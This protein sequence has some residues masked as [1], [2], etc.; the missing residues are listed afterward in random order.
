M[1]R[2]SFSLP[3][4][5]HDESLRTGEAKEIAEAATANIQ[6]EITHMIQIVKG[7]IL[8]GALL[9]LA[10]PY[11]SLSQVASSSHGIPSAVPVVTGDARVDKLLAEMTL[12]E[13][14]SLVH[15]ELEP[16]KKFQG[17]PGFLAGIPRLGI[18]PLRFADG[19]PGVLTRIPSGGPVSTMGLAATFSRE[20][21]KA[22]GAMVARQA[23]A[24]GMDVVL[25][26]FINID[27]DITFSRSY[28]TF[29]ED[30]L[31]TGEIGAS[32]IRGVQ[33]NGVMSMAKHYVAYDTE[34][35][36]VTVGE[37]ALHEIYAAP[38]AAAS[39]AG[40]AAIMCSYNKLNG[41]YSCGNGTSLNRILKHEIGFQGFVT[42]D[43]GAVHQNTAING[44]VDMEMP[45]AGS[46]LP[47]FFEYAPPV[48][49]KR[50]QPSKDDFMEE[51][52]GVMPEEGF[53]FH[54]VEGGPPQNMWSALHAHEVN[55]STIT[56]AAG[57]LL[58][59]MDKF[60][61]LDNGTHHVLSADTID[62]NAKVIQKTGEDAAV[63]LK[64]D[65]RALPLNDSDLQS[66]ALIGP[67]ALQTIAVAHPIEKAV[68]LPERQIGTL[69]VLRKYLGD[70][71]GRRVQ[72]AVADDLTGNPVPAQVL[73]HD[74][75]PGIVRR[76][77]NKAASVVAVDAQIDFT[78]KKGN[79]LPAN[80]S[81]DWDGT[82]S[83]PARAKYHMNLQ[84]LGCYGVL[85]IDG[86]RIISNGP[87]SL[88]GEITQAGQDGVLPT[89]DGLDNLRALVELA[90]G[91]HQISVSVRPDTSSN[92]AQVRLNWVT[93]EEQ[94][95]NYADSV[96]LAGKV[97]TAVV[98]AWSRSRGGG[99]E[100]PGNQNK[101]I[102][103]IA[104]IN[105]NTIV[106][107]NVSQPVLMPWIG[108]VKAVLQM[109]WPGDE[110]GWSTANV[111]TGRVNPGG[112]LPFTWGHSL[113]EYPMGD[114]SHP[115]RKA[116]GVDG[117]TIFSE[118]I[119]IGYRWFDKQNIDPL[120]PFGFGLSY[121]KFSYSKV[122][123]VHTDDGG[124]DVSFTLQNTGARDGDEVAQVYVDGPV[125]EPNDGA[126]FAIRS[127]AG[128]ERV[129]LAAGEAKVVT[130]HIAPRA[131]EYWS[132]AAG[133]WETA[134]GP[135]KVRVGASS[136]DL[137]LEAELNVQ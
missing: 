113:Q 121:T 110:G 116:D 137:R 3:V 10:T 26:P 53:S 2:S 13:K 20:D 128:F 32:F 12:A 76:M 6:E 91:P 30:P 29:G 75:K 86:R 105:P 100:L 56:A 89:T 62:M 11:V 58:L 72:F 132:T 87:M 118:G 131:F 61:Y 51:W 33:A 79:A 83:V 31:L 14:I 95:A 103:D 4:P 96:A 34:G 70:T 111:L 74:G 27:R 107:L 52:V 85:R 127:L 1:R 120:F 19:P 60:G 80:S 130:L 50:T 112:R 126:Q 35:D 90:K 7:P 46:W 54:R 36:D 64:N 101:L 125:R 42:S 129:H 102:E 57:R 23:A 41:E 98:F 22:N 92:P 18:P 47:N 43:W 65:S 135:R 78:R 122:K 67:G 17:Q 63:L 109:W 44:G 119:L 106:V 114:P 81:F 40:V 69:D 134:R 25:E 104:A 55:E 39:A 16:S 71:D 94:E 99:M 48:P 15:G 77:G 5:F 123:L 38:F 124:E 88:H 93:P 66:V 115:E 24:R 136:R 108:K 49:P 9:L 82:I 21:A 59:Q 97:K 84:V 8:T 68:G 117:R 45:G 73:T 28:N 37:Q 133:R